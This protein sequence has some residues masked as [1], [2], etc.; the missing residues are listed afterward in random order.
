[1]KWIVRACLVFLWTIFAFGL[2]VFSVPGYY[3]TGP[4]NHPVKTLFL[5]PLN[6][7]IVLFHLICL[8]AVSYALLLSFKKVQ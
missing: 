5:E 7:L 4:L 1:M 3:R 8:V 2:I 6:I